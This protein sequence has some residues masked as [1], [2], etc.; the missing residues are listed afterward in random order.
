[1][2]STK[3]RDHIF[4][5][6]ATE[7]WPFV[8]WLALRLTAEGYR[9]WCDRFKLLGGESYP[10]D[11]DDAMKNGTFRVVAVLSRNSLKKPNPVKERTLALNLAKERGENFV[12]PINLDGLSA[13]DIDWMFSDITYVPFFLSWAEGLAQLLENLEKSGAP[14]EV[15]N[16]RSAAARWF[17]TKGLIVERE[18][19]L[20][21]NVAQITELP[22]DIHRY[23][24]EDDLS[25]VERLEMLRIWPHSREDKIFWS[26]DAPP[27]ELFA[28]YRIG[29]RG[30]ITDWQTARSG[31]IDVKNLGTRVLND[32]LKSQCLAR[33]LRLTPDN[34]LCYFPDGLLRSNRL[35]FVGYDNERSW[36]RAVGIRNF[37]TLTGRESCRYHLAPAIRVWLGHELGNLVQL[38]VRLH[39]TTT[40]GVPLD[41]KSALRRRKK[42]C[43]NWWNYEW[44]SRTLAI[45]QFLTGEE[46]ELRIGKSNSQRLVISK[47]PISTPIGR[48]LDEEQI[49]Q[50]PLVE[51]GDEVEETVVELDELEADGSEVVDDE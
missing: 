38:R 22:T 31:D 3:S 37:K 33:G 11:I 18:E 14:K 49:E 15:K 43:R 20:W 17:D 24:I 30:K 35:T 46:L 42:L 4:I 51:V 12:I 32:S 45:F 1:M 36:V 28:K 39:L 41:E 25:A 47:W 13:T 6:Y 5:S 9:I 40:Q 2:E 16:G 10:R 27:G 21:S 7:D 50:Q 8:E 34:S 26:F 44:L 23:E 29:E 19:R 48:S